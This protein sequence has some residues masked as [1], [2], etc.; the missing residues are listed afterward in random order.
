M[1]HANNPE[2]ISRLKRVEGHMRSVVSM[3]E[4]GRSCLDIAQQLH[5]VENAVANAKKDM[6]RHHMEHTLEET[7]GRESSP[8]RSLLKDLKTLAKYL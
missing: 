2:I 7:L 6:I 5:A 8:A 1:A 3:L 4:D